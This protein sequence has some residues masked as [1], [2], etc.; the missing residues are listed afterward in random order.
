MGFC[1]SKRVE[2]TTIG[3]PPLFTCS[4]THGVDYLYDES[5]VYLDGNWEIRFLSDVYF[6]FALD[7]GLI[8][9]FL[10]GGGGSGSGYMYPT[11]GGCGGGGGFTHTELAVAIEKNNSYF[12]DIGEGGGVSAIIGH[13]NNGE[14]TYA[15][16]YSASGGCSGELT[17]GGAGGSGGGGG[18][19]TGG[20]GG[21]NGSDGFEGNYEGGTGQGTTTTAFGEE[22]GELFAGGGGGRLITTFST[23]ITGRGSGRIPFG[24][25]V[26]SS[27]PSGRP[28]ITAKSVARR[29]E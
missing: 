1:Y 4:G 20:A 21:Y 18:L 2:R 13:G 26:T 3:G 28:I 23:V 5:T 24:S 17:K 19:L 16:G 10:V 7:P 14:T 11:G 15:F 8:D 25:P 29:V 12:I 22:D 9:V 27:T 6:A